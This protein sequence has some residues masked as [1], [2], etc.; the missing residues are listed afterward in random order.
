MVALHHHLDFLSLVQSKLRYMSSNTGDGGGDDNEGEVEEDSDSDSDSDEE[1]GIPGNALAPVTVPK[2]LPEVP[3]LA[4]NRNPVF[5]RF[6][7]MIEV[8]LGCV[9]I[10]VH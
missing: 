5:P 4:M 9:S 2:W 3:V 7:K 1:F 8:R 6:V 10:V